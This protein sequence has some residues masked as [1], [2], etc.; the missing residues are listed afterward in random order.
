MPRETILEVLQAG[1]A[2]TRSDLDQLTDRLVAV[3]RGDD[4]LQAEQV[5]AL[6]LLA[7]GRAL[8][9]SSLMQEI[10]VREELQELHRLAAG[11]LETLGRVEK[12]LD[13]DPRAR[14]RARETLVEDLAPAERD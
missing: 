8:R 2:E 12:S 4:S 1:L 3:Y 10:A 5:V 6:G 13:V 9:E 7:C 11:I 14:R